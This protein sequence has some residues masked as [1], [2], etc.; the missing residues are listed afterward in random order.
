MHEQKVDEQYECVSSQIMD[1]VSRV[2]PI[3]S[4]VMSRLAT[5]EKS[6]Q[7]ERKKEDVERE[8]G[9]DEADQG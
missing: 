7:D 5:N 1:F 2:V 9:K 6:K 3:I 8:T 4:E